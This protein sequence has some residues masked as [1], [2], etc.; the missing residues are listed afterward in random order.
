M[1][2]GL[3]D[4]VAIVAAASQG[5][6]FAVAAGLAAEGAKLAIC[7]RDETRIQAAAEKLRMQHNADVFAQAVDVTDPELIERFVTSV[8][9]RFGRIDICVTN[10]GGP[11]AKG[12]L[13]TTYEEWQKAVAA[14]F[15]SVVFFAKQVIPYMQRARWGRL[16]TITS[17]SVKQ[18]V[19][20]LVYSNAVRTAVVGLV[21]SLANEFGKDGILVNNVG[22]GFTATDRLKELA[23]ARSKASGSSQEQ[24]FSQWAADTA[25]KRMGSPEELADVV[26]WLASERASNVTGQ[27]ILVDGGSYKGTY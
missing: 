18:P 15:L 20:D 1:Q 26:V 21:K 24:I 7:S 5:L 10:A 4:R 14:N 9:Q 23:S 19:P 13:S 27:T 8:A 11:P 3:K 12:F 25:V 2:T 17:V 6:G 16:I 22:P